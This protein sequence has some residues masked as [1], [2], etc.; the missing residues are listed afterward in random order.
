LR[1]GK[2][3]GLCHLGAQRVPK[4]STATCCGQTAARL[5]IGGAVLARLSA[6]AWRH[7]SI[8]QSIEPI[9]LRLPMPITAGEYTS[10]LA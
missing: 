4:P 1:R 10:L 2:H 3:T 7:C 8:S 5:A 6:R 9:V